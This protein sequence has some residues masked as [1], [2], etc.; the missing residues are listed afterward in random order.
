MKLGR[1]PYI[2]VPSWLRLG[3][4]EDKAYDVSA[5]VRT[6]W[7]L[8]FVGTREMSCEHRWARK[9]EVDSLW[10]YNAEELW[11]DG[12]DVHRKSGGPILYGLRWE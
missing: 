3:E 12:S 5:D 7:G 6:R 1:G 10:E 4:V 11:R 8:V 9:D 2:S